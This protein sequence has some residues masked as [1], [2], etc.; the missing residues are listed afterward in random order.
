VENIISDRDM[1]RTAFIQAAGHRVRIFKLC[2]PRCCA[3]YPDT[4]AVRSILA[5]YD[6]GKATSVPPK[7][8]MVAFGEIMSLCRDLKQ[9]VV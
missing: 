4:P 1:K 9:G 5:D 8:I 3:E 7:A 2:S 6:A